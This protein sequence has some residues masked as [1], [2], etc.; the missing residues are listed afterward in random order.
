MSPGLVK[1]WISFVAI[2]LFFLA[3]VLI[4]ASRNKLKGFWRALT[5]S[6]AYFFLVVA[7]LIVIL[8]VISGAPGQ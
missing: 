4:M 6:F 8:I 3:V 7:G 5:A 1:M 2:L